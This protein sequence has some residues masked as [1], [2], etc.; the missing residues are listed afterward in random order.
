MLAVRRSA[1]CAGDLEKYV[2]IRGTARAK[3]KALFLSKYFEVGE[4]GTHVWAR[5]FKSTW[6]PEEWADR[7]SSQYEFKGHS[8][9]IACLVNAMYKDEEKEVFYEWKNGM[10]EEGKY[11]FS[12]YDHTN[13]CFV[14]LWKDGAPDNFLDF[15]VTEGDLKLVDFDLSTAKFI[16]EDLNDA[17]AIERMKE[18][19][20]L[21]VS[22]D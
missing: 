1:T 10:R 22:D 21:E 8:E 14:P 3:D 12:A 18:I 20:E 19:E 2:R 9:A 5:G 4:A 13:R 6:T 16:V 15:F 11:C 17:I 7:F